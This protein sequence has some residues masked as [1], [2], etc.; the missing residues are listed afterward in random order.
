MACN[1]NKADKSAIWK[2]YKAG[3]DKHRIA[4]QMMIQ[5]SL[6][7]ECIA[8]G[9]PDVAPVIRTEAKAAKNRAAKSKINK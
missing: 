4:S 8:N 1:C 5:L 3:I 7:E 6:V 9:N 2:R